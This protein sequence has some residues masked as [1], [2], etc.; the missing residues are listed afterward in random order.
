[1]PYTLNKINLFP[2]EILTEKLSTANV[3]YFV[4]EGKCNMTT[5][6]NDARM[7]LTVDTYRSYDISKDV[8]IEISNTFNEPCTLLEVTFEN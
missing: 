3:H 2:N 1:M 4:L 6:Y 7:S 5:V 8:Y